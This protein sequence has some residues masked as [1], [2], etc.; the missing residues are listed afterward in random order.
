VGKETNDHKSQSRNRISQWAALVAAF[1]AALGVLSRNMAFGIAL[2]V[3]FGV[4][5]SMLLER[6]K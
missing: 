3:L 6:E 2:G 1:G 4:V 5:V